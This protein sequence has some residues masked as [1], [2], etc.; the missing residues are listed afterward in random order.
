MSLHGMDPSAKFTL[1]EYAVDC[2]ERSKVLATDL[3][4]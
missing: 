2:L 1:Y 3:S 4:Y